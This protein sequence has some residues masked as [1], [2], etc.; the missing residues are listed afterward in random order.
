MPAPW[1]AR[2]CATPW[3]A[4]VTLI[5]AASR[6]VTT[7]LVL[8]LA[9]VQG[10]NAWTSASPGYADFANMW[11]GR[12]YNIVAVVGYPSTLPFTADG[13]VGESAWAFMPGYPAI[14]RLLMVLV[15]QPW[16]PMAVLV[17]VAFSLGAALLFYRLMRRVLDSSTALFSVVLFCVAPLSPLLQFGYAESMYLFLLTLALLLLLQRRY[18]LLFPVI[19][20][21]ALTRPSGLAFALALGLHTVYR[22]VT[23]RQDPFPAADRVLAASVTGYSLLAGLAWPA[24][25]WIGTGSITAYTDTELAWRAP[26]IGYQELIPFTAWFQSGVWW[27]GMPLGIVAVIVLI[28]LFGAA[29]FL[30]P[31]KRLGVDLRLWL[32]SYALYLLAVFFP[33]SSTFRLLMPMFP[34]LGALAPPRNTGYRIALVLAGILGQWGWLL[35]CWGVDG[36]D[37]TPP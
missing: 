7:A 37:W 5:W 14:V 23:R 12:W 30:P 28:L 34:L 2:Y 18:A 22:A 21:M 9:N 31:V 32:A 13:H 6:I 3:W 24:I 36:A 8:L 26:Y 4:R 15:G 25:A 11:D 33:Q 27:L 20:V 1:R 16:A 35:L 19:T 10:P 29:L 17:S